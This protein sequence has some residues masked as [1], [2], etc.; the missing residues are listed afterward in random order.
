MSGA[1]GGSGGSSGRAGTGGSGNAGGAGAGG[2]GAGGAGGAGGTGGKAGAGGSGGGSGCGVS[3]VNP[4]S[5]PA[6]R[7]VLCYL[8]QINK[9]STLSGVQDCSWSPMSDVAYAFNTTGVYPAIVGGDFL[10]TNAVS[11]ATTAWNARSLS[12]IRYHM[13]RP[14]DGDSYES[15]MGTTDLAATLTPGTSRYNGLMAKIDSA[16]TKLLQL[17][18]AGV[19]VLWAPYHEAQPNGWFWWSKGTGAQFSQLWNLMFERFRSRGVNNVIWIMPFSGSP[20]SSFYPGKSVVDISGSDTYGDSQP[21]ASNYRNTVTAVGS[22]TLPLALH[23]TGYVPN[24][25]DMFN[26]AQ[27]PWVLFSVWCSADW[28]QNTSRNSAAELRQAF[29]NPRTIN[30]GG[31]PQF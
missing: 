22:S 17:Q 26:N 2:A 27:A 18:N 14:E 23:E 25:T 9:Q 30:R 12:M 5:I 31:M 7:N 21:F 1:P 8:Y 11:Q 16:A 20:S 4:N 13:G 3:P 29:T 6:V 19:V 28:L 10:Y 24:P 15:S